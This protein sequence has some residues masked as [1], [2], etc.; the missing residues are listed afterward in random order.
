MSYLRSSLRG[1]A[2]LYDPRELDGHLINGSLLQKSDPTSVYLTSSVIA[3]AAVTNHT[4]TAAGHNQTAAPGTVIPLSTLFTYSDSDGSSDIVSFDVRDS[5]SGGG[6]LQHNGV[7]WAD[8]QLTPDQPIS[9]ISQWSYVVGP[10]G[11]VDTIGFNVTDKAGAFNPTVTATVTSAATNHTPTASPHNQTAAPGTVIPLSTLFTYSDAD[12]L[13]DIVSFDV[14]DSTSGGGHLQH[15]GVAWADGQLTPDQPISSISQWSYVVGPS[16]SVDTI[17]FNVT[18]KAGAFNP[19]VTA[20]VTSAATNH[21]PTASPHN[22]T[23][24]PGTVIPLSTLFT[25]SD[26][27]GLSDIVSFDVRDSTSGGGHLQHN[28]VAWADGQLTPDQPISSI[29]EWS[30]VV[31]PNGS[32]DT[33][34]FNVTD[35]AGAFN[36]TV[37]ATVTST[38]SNHTPAA[39]AHDQSAAPGTVIPLSTLFTYSDA[40]GSSDIISFDVRDA[41]AGG[42]HLQHNG[43]AWA[44]GQL[45]PDQP[46][47]T[48]SEWSYVVGPNGSVDTIGFNVTDK[49]GAFNPTVTATVTSTGSNHTPTAIA[50]DQSATPGTVIPLSSL[51]TYSDADGLS[52]IVSFDVRDQTTGGGHLQHNGQ[53]WPDGNLTPDQP[54]GTIGEWSYVAGPGGSVDTVGFNVTDKA[55]AFNSTVRATVTTG[56]G[57]TSGYSLSP[58]AGSVTEGDQL[59][60]TITRPPGLAAGRLYFSTLSD[61]TATYAEGDYSTTSG[62]RP[63]NMAID[64]SAGETTKTLILNITND[65]VSDSGEQFRAIIQKDGGNEPITSYLAR[66]SYVTIYDSDQSADP[67]S[68]TTNNNTFALFTTLVAHAAEKPP[69]TLLRL[70]FASG[71]VGTISQVAGEGDHTHTTAATAVDFGLPTGTEVRAMA[72]GVIV[73][74]ESGHPNFSAPKTVNFNNGVLTPVDPSYDLGPGQLG[75]FITVK[76]TIVVDGVMRTFYATYAHLDPEIAERFKGRGGDVFTGMT[77]GEVGWTGAITGPHVHVQVGWLLDPTRI[78]TGPDGKPTPMIADGR[79]SDGVHDSLSLMSMLVFYEGSLHW[80]QTPSLDSSTITSQNDPSLFNEAENSEGRAGSTANDLFVLSTNDIQSAMHIYAS[81]KNAVIGL[82]DR[83]TQYIAKEFEDIRIVGSEVA[84]KLNI[85]SLFGTTIKLNTVYFDGGA[86]DDFVD[87]SQ[88][89]RRVAAEGGDGADRLIGGLAD[90]QLSGGDADDI[91]DGGPGADYLGGGFGDDSYLIDNVSDFVVEG[92]DEG[93]NDRIYTSISYTL[94][95]GVYVEILSTT[96]EEGTDPLILAGNELDNRI[97]GNAG[98]NTLY[99]MGGNDRLEGLAGDD[100]YIIDTAGDQVIEAVGQG[101]DQVFSPVSYTLAAGGEVEVLSTTDRLGTQAIDLTGNEFGNALYGNAATNVLSGGGGD[102]LLDGGAGADTM[103]GGLGNDSYVVDAANDVVVEAAGEG[104]DTVFSGVSYTLAAGTEVEVLSTTD[105]AGTQ[106]I[107]LTGN[108]FGNALF[109]NAAAN[110]LVGLDGDDILDGGAG[111]DRMTGGLGNDVYVVDDAGDV[112]TEN[113]GEGTDEIRTTLS[114][115]TIADNVEK[116]TGIGTGFQTLR[117]N[118]GNNAIA[119]GAA[120]GFVDF[121][122]GGTDTGTGNVGVDVFYFGAT[123]DQSDKADGGA[124]KDV[125]VLQGNYSGGVT[126]GDHAL[127][128][129]ETLSILSHS[130]ARFGGGGASPFTYVIHSVDGNVAAGQ[131]LIVNA[132][133]LEA[134]ENFT[135]DGSAEHDGGFFI[136]GGK[137]DDHLTGGS[138]LD[139]FFFAE[140]GRFGAN[141][142]VNGG[143]GSD[144]LVLRGNYTIDM[145]TSTVTNVETVTLMSGSDSRFFSTTSSFSYDIKTADTT[146][147]AGASMT[148]NGGGL[149]LGETLHFDGSAEHDGGIYRVFGGADADVIKGGSGNDLIFGGLGGDTLSGGGGADTFRYQDVAEST[150]ASRDQILDFA[151][152]DKIDLSRIDAISGTGA[153]DAFT[154][155]NSFSGHAGELTATNGGSGNVWTVSGD[156]DGDGNADFQLLV[157]V[158]DG[159]AL[160]SADFAL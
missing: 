157:T 45:T 66:S 76:H 143:A 147:A 94:G 119:T 54:I 99:G 80:P 39:V 85:G 140:D 16:G 90:D 77:L 44:D 8:G 47:S 116:L 51:F 123:L 149:H 64:F 139:V 58:A 72:D 115:Y 11:S 30:Y 60:F 118:A 9:S 82:V 57:A 15:N 97:I 38:T 152:G 18:D 20:T 34:G 53:P 89:D 111:A 10:N 52:D 68:A 103:R 88:T 63:A 160:S 74:V 155:V 21:T 135:F 141:D 26:A 92:A 65:H 69:Q 50:R 124:G 102:D 67:I 46:I 36:P 112:V 114:S 49:A 32:V 148:F 27:D 84:D 3:T 146:V 105:R 17:G 131:Q 122:A 110:T 150:M 19:T 91:L 134:G 113:A 79:S 2:T 100:S 29:S 13:S 75:N 104:R 121:S 106:S 24:V 129:I 61:G 62:G 86:G 25:Y 101:Y 158:A 142:S 107:D 154:F 132:S 40:D 48:I 56:A 28:G 153:N 127:D 22:Q 31:G 43:T 120:G 7:A 83:A 59:T 14:R 33:I 55:G 95:T 78:G 98:A 108:E 87:G 42:G 12:G 73:Y 109:G 136:Y 145:A 1:R 159:R 6:H 81:G 151:N 5:T 117:G 35:K 137:G 125:A 71:V 128:N 130:D 4:P 41:T 126:L 138:G 23:A 144:I 96:D 37:T 133:T 93:A 70:P 156:V